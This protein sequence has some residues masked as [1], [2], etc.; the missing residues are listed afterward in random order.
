MDDLISR[1]STIWN[2]PGF[3]KLFTE[4]LGIIL[5]FV[6]FFYIFEIPMH[7]INYFLQ[8]SFL[9]RQIRES[10]KRTDPIDLDYLATL[11]DLKK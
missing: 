7:L 1:L 11:Y 10:L 9:Y 5:A 8:K 2:S 4:F 6:I 3:D